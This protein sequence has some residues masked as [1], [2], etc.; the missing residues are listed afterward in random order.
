ME[1]INN[2]DSNKQI[3]DLY[4][5]ST[6]SMLSNQIFNNLEFNSMQLINQKFIPVLPDEMIYLKS[7]TCLIMIG[8]GLTQLPGVLFK[9]PNL[10]KL[11]LSENWIVQLPEE[12]NF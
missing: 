12:V 8:C 6:E 11:N 4:E 10:L 5:V 7:L 3:N 9:L 2:N 1:Q